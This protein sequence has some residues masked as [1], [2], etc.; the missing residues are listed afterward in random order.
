MEVEEKKKTRMKD[1]SIKICFINNINY[2]CTVK[3]INIDHEQ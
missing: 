1:F 2:I 3:L